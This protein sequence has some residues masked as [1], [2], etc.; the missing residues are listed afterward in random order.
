[1]GVQA[2]ERGADGLGLGIR[3]GAVDAV[4]DEL[5]R[6]AG[7]GR[8]DHGLAG[9]ECFEGHVSEVLVEGRVD[10]AER[11]GVEVEQRPIVDGARN[12][13]RSPRPSESTSR[14]VLAR[15]VPSPAMTSR[16]PRSTWAS[17]R[18]AEVDPLDALDAADREDV[19][20]VRAWPDLLGQPRRMI[21]RS[22]CRPL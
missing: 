2:R 21:Q 12:V 16:R 8:G 3:D 5:Q 22:A 17:A 6:P 13:T 10:D 9:Q 11:A 20:A 18:T 7:V 1:M 19:V 14:S 4:D 15:C